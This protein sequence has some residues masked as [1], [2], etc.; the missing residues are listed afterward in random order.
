M[1]FTVDAMMVRHGEG[2]EDYW[3]RVSQYPA[4]LSVKDAERRLEEIKRPKYT[5]GAGELLAEGR[6]QCPMLR[7]GIASDHCRRVMQAVDGAVTAD[8]YMKVLDHGIC[9]ACPV[10]QAVQG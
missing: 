8:D 7:W 2:P 3:R 4:A 6:A 1:F 5:V 9:R 10:R